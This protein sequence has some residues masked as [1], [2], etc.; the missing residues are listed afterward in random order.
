MMRHSPK[1]GWRVSSAAIH[2]RGTEDTKKY[3][4]FLTTKTLR[5]EQLYKNFTYFLYDFV[6]LWFK[7]IISFSLR[8]LRLCGEFFIAVLFWI[9]L[10]ISSRRLFIRRTWVPGQKSFLQEG[11]R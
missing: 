9:Y 3:K 10:K 2:H 11:Q 4:I 5:H 7:I 8:T 6:S 1:L